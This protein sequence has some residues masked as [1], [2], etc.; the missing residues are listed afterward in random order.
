M[1]SVSLPVWIE[2]RLETAPR[3]SDRRGLAK[4][5]T[6]LLGPISPRTLEE[7]PLVWQ[8]VNGRAVTPTRDAIALAY[9]RFQAAPKYRA[10]RTKKT[11]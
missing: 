11:A 3:Y 2:G 4:L 5:H 6:E 8:L 7:W 10:G 1:N 9:E